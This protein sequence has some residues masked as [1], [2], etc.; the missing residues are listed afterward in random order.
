M[1][2]IEITK[3]LMTY[4]ERVEL[5]PP[6]S[7]KEI[8]NF[9]TRERITLPPSYVELLRQFDGGEIFI[10]GTVL[11]GI[12]ESSN[13]PTVKDA[14]R[15]ELRRSYR[16][17]RTLLIIG[18]LNYGDFVCIDLNGLNELIIWNHE[19]DEAD[20]KWDSLESWLQET[21]MDYKNHEKGF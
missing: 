15:S 21:I 10:P 2:I 19:L 12:N 3:E 11:Y 18:K 9:Q 17:P 14:N 6:V 16:I 20:C 1:S 8:S 13:N 7:E 4:G 5:N